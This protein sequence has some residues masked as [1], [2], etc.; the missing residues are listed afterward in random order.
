MYYDLETINRIA[1]RQ[2]ADTEAAVVVCSITLHY[3]KFRV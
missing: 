2:S 1:S 3:I